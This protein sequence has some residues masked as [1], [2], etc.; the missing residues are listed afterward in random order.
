MRCFAVAAVTA[1]AVRRDEAV[2]LPILLR[3]YN[4]RAWEIHAGTA[5]WMYSRVEQAFRRSGPERSA[6]SGVWHV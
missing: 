3:V 4:F 2:T 6:G 1:C 5:K